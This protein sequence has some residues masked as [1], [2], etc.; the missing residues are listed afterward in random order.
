MGKGKSST[1]TTINYL[2]YDNGERLNKIKISYN[3]KNLTPSSIVDKVCN[4]Y[5]LTKGTIASSSVSIKKVFI[6]VSIYNL[7][8]SAYTEESKRTGKNYMVQYKGDKLYVV[9]VFTR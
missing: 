6:G 1:G 3:I 5:S 9:E 4:E 7:I 8:M 2:A